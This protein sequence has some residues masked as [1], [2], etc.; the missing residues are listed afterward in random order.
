MHDVLVVGAGPSGSWAGMR[1]AEKGLDVLMLDAARFPR[2]KACGGIVGETAV[3]LIGNDVLSL[4][5]A[6]GHGNELFF[7]WQPIGFIGRHEYYFKRR[8]FDHYLVRRA[9]ASGA[10]LLEDRRVTKVDVRPEGVVVEANGETHE[11]HL[12]IGAE[13]TNSVVGRSVR[14]T[15]HDGPYKYASI[16]A[17]ID[18]TPEQIARLGV[19][20]PPH[21]KTYFFSDLLGFGWIVANERS[22]N[23]GLGAMMRHANGLRPRFLDFLRRVDLPPQDVRGAQIPYLPL[24][25]VYADR[26]LLT[27]DAGGFVNPWTGCGIDDGILASERAAEVAKL[28]VDR[29]DFTAATL[30]QFQDASRDHLRWIVKRGRWMKGL[31]LIMPVGKRFPRWVKHIVRIAAQWA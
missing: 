2:D 1:C 12:V 3:R 18:L 19:H 20:D 4:L 15:H 21:Q 5:E 16:K 23:A 25:R 31:D 10:K 26:V 17:E 8:R 6:E 13:G 27:G 22:V 9:Q 28:A 30:R 24:R 11:A 7:D 14:L 29:A